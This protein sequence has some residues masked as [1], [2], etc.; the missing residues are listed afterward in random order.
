MINDKILDV[1]GGEPRSPCFRASL[2][3]PVL[4]FL[5]TG[6]FLYLSI[7]NL[8]HRKATQIFSLIQK[9]LD[10]SFS[11]TNEVLFSPVEFSSVQVNIFIFSA[12]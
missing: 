7:F 8:Q 4:S 10:V 3:P 6:D 12:H 5:S 11:G 1:V 2:I 9:H